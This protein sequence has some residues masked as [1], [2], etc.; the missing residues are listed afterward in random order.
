MPMLPSD[1]LGWET[2]S[3]A[4]ERRIRI[5]PRVDVQPRLSHV[6]F[7]QRRWLSSFDGPD[8]R[9]T[10][11]VFVTQP[12]YLGICEYASSDMQNEVGGVLI[13]RWRRDAQDGAD[14]IVVE[15]MIPAR[16]TRH[17]SAFLTFTQESLLAL[18]QD[19]ESCF[20][21]KQ[22]VGWFHTHP[23]MGVFLSEYD[24]W[25]AEHF[26]P[27][28]WQ[29]S[30][31]IEPHSSTGGFFVRDGEGRLPS[32]HYTGFNEI[33]APDGRSRMQWKNLAA[34]RLEIGFTG[35]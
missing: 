29:A 26:F 11:R 7:M 6:P 22:I 19:Q 24:L 35:G 16:H 4:G 8:A 10:V 12:A 23:R 25:L 30:L 20:P 15:A 1:N 28:P 14:F 21:R 18:H 27:E 33:L 31:V 5:A 3:F 2:T 17:G 34:E 13:G 32:Y 9:W